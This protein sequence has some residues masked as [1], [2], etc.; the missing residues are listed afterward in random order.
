MLCCPLQDVFLLYIDF[1]SIWNINFSFSSFFKIEFHWYAS[2]QL[3]FETNTCIFVH[4]LF[5]SQKEMKEIKIYKKHDETS[6]VFTNF[7]MQWWTDYQTVLQ[8]GSKPIK[9]KQAKVKFLAL[10]S[11]SLRNINLSELLFPF[12]YIKLLSNFPFCFPRFLFTR[13]QGS[14]NSFF[15]RGSKKLFFFSILYF[16]S[17]VIV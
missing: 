3:Q 11:N 5:C 12:F 4:T 10:L 15:W 17:I 13:I 6:L 1:C 9:R 2:R 14:K 8:W 7:K 16:T